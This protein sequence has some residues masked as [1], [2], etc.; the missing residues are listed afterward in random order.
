MKKGFTLIE[1]L[2]VIGIVV[3]LSVLTVPIGIRFYQSQIL[4]DTSENILI[5]LRRAHMQAVS[6][7][8]D[9]SFGVKFYPDSYILFQGDSYDL[10]DQSEDEIFN[11]TSGVSIDGSDEISFSKLEGLSGSN[12]NLSVSLYNKSQNIN[13][14]EQGKVEK[15]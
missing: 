5:T 8:N 15:Q 11:L 13:V 1:L 10:R 12:V 3:T 2:L 7:K 6:Q 9:S 14:N 4:E